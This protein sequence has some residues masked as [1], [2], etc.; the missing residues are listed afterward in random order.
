MPRDGSSAPT[1]YQEP[2]YTRGI[3]ELIKTLPEAQRPKRV[4]I[5]TAQNPFTIVDREGFQGQGGALN[6]AKAA[7]MSVVVDEQ[8]P[9]STT[10]FTGLIQKAK[11]ANADLLL[12]L[13]PAQ[14][15]AAGG[16]HGKAAGL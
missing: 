1:P 16:P 8:Y 15:R 4:A 13:G 14:R 11:A 9:P 5:L 12:E 7:G 3:F 10:D 6:F 2:D